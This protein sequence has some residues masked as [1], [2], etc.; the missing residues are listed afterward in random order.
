MKQIAIEDSNLNVQ[1]LVQMAEAEPVILT[2]NG[3]PVVGVL[4]VDEADIEAWSLGSN[5]DFIA[6][7]ERFRE[8]GRREGGIP[9]EEV[10]RR[11][12]IH[13]EADSAI[14]PRNLP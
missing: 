2:R 6:M 9:L 4:E 11:W 10:R 14:D 13:R 3:T 1:E 7:I 8:R 12:S 5:L